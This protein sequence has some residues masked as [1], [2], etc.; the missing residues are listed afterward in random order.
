[1]KG[2]VFLIVKKAD[3]CSDMNNEKG[4]IG[5]RHW[6]NYSDKI[7][8]RLGWLGAS[9]VL[10]GYYLNANK[11]QECWVVWVFGN[12]LMGLYCLNRGAFPAAAMSFAISAMNIYGL[13][14]W[15]G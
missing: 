12:V 3:A 10:L 13:I 4:N 9:L 2:H 11:H 8:E 14:M 5:Y 15:T 6:R 7:T 1:M